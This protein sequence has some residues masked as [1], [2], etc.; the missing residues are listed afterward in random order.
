MDPHRHI[1]GGYAVCSV[2]RA[3]ADAARSLDD[4]RQ[5]RAIV[6]ESVQRRL[7]TVVAL[8]RELEAAATHRTRLLRM[9]LNEVDAGTRSAPEAEL[10]RE[11]AGSRILPS[12]HWNVA[13]VASD[14]SSL[15]VPDGWIDESGIALEVDSREFHLTP[16][17]WQRTMRRH[18]E[19][20]AHGALVLH[21]TPSEIR[22]GR[23]RVRQ[24][25]ERAHTGRLA[26]GAGAAIRIA[27]QA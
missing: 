17:G 5:V 13:L 16:E 6:A 19:L 21:F 3:V 1:V 7:T 12:V 22:R 11:L 9:A 15:P 23:G 27:A 18:N 4:L 24:I 20:A 2:A 10:A 8:R 26:S 25:V 14:G